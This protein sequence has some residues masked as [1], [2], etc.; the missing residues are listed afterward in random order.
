MPHLAL[1]PCDKEAIASGAWLNDAIITAAQELLKKS[2]KGICGFQSTQNGRK[3]AFKPIKSGSDFVQLFHI[4]NSHWVV[5]SNIGCQY[6]AIGVYDSNCYTTTVPLELKRQICSLVQT[7]HDTIV[8][9]VMNI[10]SQHN[11]NDCGLY[12]LANATELVMKGNP[13]L[14]VWDANK[15]RQHLLHCLENEQITNFPVI[16]QRQIAFGTRTKKSF[17][18]CERIYCICRMPEDKSAMIKCEK[19]LKWYHMSCMG[20][21]PDVNHNGVAWSCTGCLELVNT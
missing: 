17:I 8:F 20:L 14:C 15:M 19:C 5:A 13:V 18:F 1:L 11:T 3:L 21:D 7:K 9:E 2:S 4:H 12:A 6:N 10:D 16:K